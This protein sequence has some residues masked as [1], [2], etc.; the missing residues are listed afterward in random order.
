LSSIC[1]FRIPALLFPARKLESIPMRLFAILVPLIFVSFMKRTTTRVKHNIDGASRKKEIIPMNK[2]AIGAFAVS[3]VAGATLIGF[4][5]SSIEGRN[6]VQAKQIALYEATQQQKSIPPAGSLANSDSFRN[7]KAV[8]QSLVFELK[9][10]ARVSEGTYNYAVKQGMK[11]IVF[12]YGT[13]SIGAPEWGTVAQKIVVPAD[14]LSGDA[15]L[16]L[17]VYEINQEN[18]ERVNRI[19]TPLTLDANAGING[20]DA[21]RN[22]KAAPVSVNYK[23]TGEA[24]MLEGTYL[25]TVK[26]DRQEIVSG[27]GTASSGAPD[28]GKMNSTIA[29]PAKNASSDS[30]LSLE[31]FSRDEES[32]DT[33]GKITVGLT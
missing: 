6:F 4:L 29:V 18:G 3:V 10:E 5:T 33:V 15:P 7:V 31:L 21:F 8:K 17:E 26:Q 30:P 1:T 23:I 9:G 12:G 20:N 27:F 16:V 13:A 11:T 14:K 19:R 25:Y 32:G 24:R 2:I 28:W 22:L